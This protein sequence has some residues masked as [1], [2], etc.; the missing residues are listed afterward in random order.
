MSNTKNQLGEITITGSGFAIGPG[1]V[2]PHI[3]YPISSSLL[4]IETNLIYIFIIISLLVIFEK[5]IIIFLTSSRLKKN[6]NAMMLINLRARMTIHEGSL[7]T[8]L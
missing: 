4:N 6:T 5:E 2:N 3:S 8:V 1:L 7:L